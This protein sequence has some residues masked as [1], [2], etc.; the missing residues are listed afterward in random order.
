MTDQATKIQKSDIDLNKEMTGSC[1]RP[2]RYSSNPLVCDCP[3]C[4]K[5]CVNPNGAKQHQPKQKSDAK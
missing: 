1:G 5:R 2:F 3:F 4:K